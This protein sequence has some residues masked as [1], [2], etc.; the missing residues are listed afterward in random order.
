MLRKNIRQR[1]EYLF[2]L[3]REQE[4][5]AKMEKKNK[6]LQAEKNNQKLPT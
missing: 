4:Q 1:R 6:I 3:E 5:K 2:T